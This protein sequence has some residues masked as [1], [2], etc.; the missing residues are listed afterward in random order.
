MGLETDNMQD[1]L[2][3]LEKIS[4]LSTCRIVEDMRVHSET[5]SRLVGHPFVLAPDLDNSSSSGYPRVTQLDLA[6]GYRC[7]PV[8]PKW[9]E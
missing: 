8:H 4:D 6:E 1:R 9:G 2:V 3:V 7:C 5:M